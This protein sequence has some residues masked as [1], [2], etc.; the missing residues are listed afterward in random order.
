MVCQQFQLQLW[1]FCIMQHLLW[2]WGDAPLRV[3]A[4]RVLAVKALLP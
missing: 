4:K 3:S 1:W 2:L